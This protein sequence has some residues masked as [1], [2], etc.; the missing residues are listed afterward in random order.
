MAHSHVDRFVK[1]WAIGGGLFILAIVFVTTANVG[2]FAFDRAVRP[3]GGSIPGLPGY[4]DFVSLAVSCA[5]L[6]F[7]PFCQLQR[8]H[9]AVDVFTE[10]LPKHLRR[11]LDRAWSAAASLL[12]LFLAYWMLLGLLESRSDGALSP[13][14]GW[15]LWPFYLPGILSLLLWAVVAALQAVEK[16]SRGNP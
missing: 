11:G 8:G 13:V 7:F 6:M 5:A 15:P 14:I 10:K 16:V 3:F 12:A 4:E 1:A 9:V 2:L